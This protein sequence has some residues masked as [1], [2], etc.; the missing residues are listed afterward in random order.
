MNT[1]GI[2][3]QRRPIPLFPLILLTLAALGVGAVTVFL[4]L[5]PQ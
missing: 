1:A 4:T 3:L 2:R 5:G